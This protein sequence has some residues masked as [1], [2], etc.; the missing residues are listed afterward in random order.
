MFGAVG[1][2]H[3]GTFFGII[4]RDALYLKVDAGNRHDYER[5][6]MDAFTPY[7]DRSG[8]MMYYRVP[9]GVLESSIE[10]AEW[11]SKAIAAAMRREQPAEAGRRRVRAPRSDVPSRTRRS[12][13]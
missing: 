2:Y 10:L 8:S 13:R 6:G 12:G 4:S 5:A 3:R 9:V 1:L 7:P 11:A